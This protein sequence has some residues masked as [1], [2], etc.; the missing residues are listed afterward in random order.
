M[1]GSKADDVRSRAQ[2]SLRVLHD[3]GAVAPGPRQLPCQVHMQRTLYLGAV[4]VRL[5]LVVHAWVVLACE[6]PGSSFLRCSILPD[7]I[8]YPC[9][10]LVNALH[11]I[12]LPIADMLQK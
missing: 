7:N 8:L 9:T 1:T 5:Y 11:L 2:H 12:S 3:G 6:K 10:A 4:E